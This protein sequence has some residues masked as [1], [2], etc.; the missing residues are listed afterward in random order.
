MS[1]PADGAWREA[2]TDDGGGLPHRKPTPAH[3]VAAQTAAQQRRLAAAAA[4]RE[5]V[6]AEAPVVVAETVIGAP[7]VHLP[8]VAQRVRPRTLS[9]RRQSKRELERGG[10]LYPAS[11]TAQYER[12]VTRGDCL[13][14]G[15]NEARPCPWVSCKHHLALDV[16]PTN[17]NIKLTFPDVE[18]WE[19]RNTCALDA[20]DEDGLTMEEVAART[21]L[22]RERVR[23]MEGQSFAKIRTAEPAAFAAALELASVGLPR[24]EVVGLTDA[25]GARSERDALDG[26]SEILAHSIPDDAEVPRGV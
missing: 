18:V 21:N 2:T 11:E 17:G 22:T 24:A 8:V 25:S 7:R 13:P 1:A 3:I 23:Q 12:P 9:M 14:G 4:H 15:C 6:A 19:M 26:L 16:N 10:V 5:R 20:A